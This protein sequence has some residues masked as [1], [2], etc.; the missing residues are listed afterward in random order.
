MKYAVAYLNFYENENQITVVEAGDPITAMVEGV[1][2]IENANGN[3]DVDKW[4]DGLLENIPDPSGYAKRI[5][6]I[7]TEFFN[8]DQA[9]SEPVPV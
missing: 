7:K 4:L 9:I 2:A 5:E 6:E 1:R 8:L 3:P